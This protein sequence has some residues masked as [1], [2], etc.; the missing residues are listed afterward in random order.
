MDTIYNFVSSC[1]LMSYRILFVS[2][3]VSSIL[4]VTFQRLRHSPS[5]PAG[6]WA[7]TISTAS[8][9]MSSLVTSNGNATMVPLQMT[10]LEAA[11]SLSFCHDRITRAATLS[12]S[13]PDAAPSF[14]PAKTRKPRLHRCK[15]NCKKDR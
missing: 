13:L 7:L 11:P 4:I 2:P 1:C 14:N 12:D 15:A 6:R 9:K 3:R 8:C 5:S 10:P